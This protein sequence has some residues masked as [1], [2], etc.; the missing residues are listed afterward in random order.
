MAKKGIIEEIFSKAKFADESQSYKIF[1]RNFERIVETTLPEFLVQSD[2]LQT[3]PI[4]RIKKI[5]KNNTVLFEKK[6]P[7]SE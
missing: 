7:G 5:E 1:Y 2:N 3:I 4:S 6:L